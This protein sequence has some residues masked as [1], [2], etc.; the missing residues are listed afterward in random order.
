MIAAE[1]WRKYEESYI[2]YGLDLRP[3]IRNEESE[4]KQKKPKQAQIKVTASDRAVMLMTVFAVA[5]CMIAIIFFHAY[6]ANIKYNINSLNKEIDGLSND[7]DNLN[8]ELRSGNSL[9]SIEYYAINDLGMVYPG[10]SQTVDV[11]EIEGSEQV[12]AYIAS[13]AA[14]QRGFVTSDSITVADAARLLFAQS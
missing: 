9:D 11:T 5:V 1:E 7:I 10:I 2:R 4:I 3:D 14:S 8:I 6:A 12:N 13:L